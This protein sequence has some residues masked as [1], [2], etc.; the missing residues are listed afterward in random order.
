MLLQYRSIIVLENKIY[1]ESRKGLSLK[2][3]IK[4]YY[5]GFAIFDKDTLNAMTLDND[6]PKKCCN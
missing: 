2:R 1:N 5:H 3:V 6:D 4:V